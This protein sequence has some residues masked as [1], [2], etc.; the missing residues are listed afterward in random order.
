[1]P[2]RYSVRDGL[3]FGEYASGEGFRSGLEEWVSSLGTVRRAMFHALPGDV[4]RFEVS[5]EV[6]SRLEHRVGA[7]RMAW[8]DGRLVRFELLEETL[9]RSEAPCLPT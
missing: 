4:V 9:A 2:S 6:E 1:M 8:R 5:S 3:L 7:W